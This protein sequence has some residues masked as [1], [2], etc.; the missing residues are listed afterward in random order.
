MCQGGSPSQLLPHSGSGAS[1]A[2]NINPPV[3][4]GKAGILSLDVSFAVS[5]LISFIFGSAFLLL[6]TLYVHRNYVAGALLSV[7]ASN[8]QPMLFKWVMMKRQQ[9]NRICINRMSHY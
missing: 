6:A 5:I 3:T 4:M 1:S 7:H 9:H 8:Q 2:S